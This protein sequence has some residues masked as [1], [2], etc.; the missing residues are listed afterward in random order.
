M[1][2]GWPHRRR[3][4]YC[5]D[6][7]GV[8]EPLLLLAPG[9]DPRSFA[10]TIEDIPANSVAVHP[11]CHARAQ[12]RAHPRAADLPRALSGRER[13]RTGGPAPAR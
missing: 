7:L 5:R 9:K 12:K 10:L 1:T 8:Y 3:C 4:V 13:D 6:V 2:D 11:S